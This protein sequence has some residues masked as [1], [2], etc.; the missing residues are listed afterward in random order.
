MPSLV[1]EILRDVTPENCIEPIMRI[2]YFIGFTVSLFGNMVRGV[3]PEKIFESFVQ[4]VY[5]INNL[6]SF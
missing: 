5:F 3:T 2:E 6:P 4:L 1:S